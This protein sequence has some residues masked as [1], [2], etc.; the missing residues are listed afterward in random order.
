MKLYFTLLFLV[1][2]KYLEAED[3]KYPLI[4][5]NDIHKKC[6][7]LIND[8]YVLRFNQFFE[9]TVFINDSTAYFNPNGSLHLGTHKG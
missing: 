2:I 7:R 3:F 5:T 6:S 9:S 4:D 1:F 8:E